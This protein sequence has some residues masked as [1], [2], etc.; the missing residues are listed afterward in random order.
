MS[1][2]CGSGRSSGSRGTGSSHFL[3]EFRQWLDRCCL[4][5]LGLRRWRRDRRRGRGPGR[6]G[7]RPIRGSGGLAA[8]LGKQSEFGHGLRNRLRSRCAPKRCRSRGLCRARGR[9]G[10][11]GGRRTRGRL[12]PSQRKPLKCG[13]GRLRTCC[14]R[15][16]LSS[17]FRSRGSFSPWPR[18]RSLLRCR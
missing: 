18:S 14:R 13:Q 12:L 17:G 16:R 6:R 3:C 9:W 10:G 11:G 2:S 8:L 5:W 15:H 4:L 7:A 1:N